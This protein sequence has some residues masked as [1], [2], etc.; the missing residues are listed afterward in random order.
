M[1]PLT[2]RSLKMYTVGMHQYVSAQA[3]STRKFTGNAAKNGQPTSGGSRETLPDLHRQR[4]ELPLDVEKDEQQSDSNH[5]RSDNRRRT[6]TVLRSA[7]IV[8][9]SISPARTIQFNL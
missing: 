6:P 3:N 5:K 9:G 1:A 8:Q 4:N 7:P 2:V